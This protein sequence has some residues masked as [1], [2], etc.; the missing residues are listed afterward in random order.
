MDN[1]DR[2]RRREEDNK[3]IFAE[4]EKWK[5]EGGKEKET[6]REVKKSGS[7]GRVKMIREVMSE[8]IPLVMSGRSPEVVSGSIPEE[9]K[10]RKKGMESVPQNI[11][12][13]TKWIKMK[14]EDAGTFMGTHAKNNDTGFIRGMVVGFEMMG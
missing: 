13:K 2:K 12:L 7:G 1:K 3:E 9:D 5:D 14:Q 6:V 8:S 10:V 11:H 4:E